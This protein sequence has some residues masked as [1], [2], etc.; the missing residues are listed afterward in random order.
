M[1]L[2][3][4]ISG[5]G[6][7]IQ[8]VAMSWLMATITPS[9]VMVALVQAATN[10]P[11][12]ILSIFAGAIVDNFNRR[13][14]MLIARALMALT[15]AT[16]T[17]LVAV[18]LI[19]PW[20]ILVFSFL[21]GCCIAFN[22]PAWQASVG[23]IVDRKD[24]AAAVTLT[25][26]GFNTVRSVGPALGGIILATFGPLTA[27]CLYTLGHFAP[28]I[29]VWRSK[30]KVP[31]PRL[32]PEAMLTAISDGIRF[33]SLSSEIK[34]ALGRGFLFGLAGIAIL[35]LLPLVVRDQLK[36][37]AVAYGILMAGFGAGALLAGL[38]STTLRRKLSDE[39]LLKLACVACATCTI[40]LSLTQTAA[41]AAIALMLGGAGWV[42]GWSGLSISVQWASP[43]WVVGRTISLYYAL[44]SCGLA[45]GS[46]LWG[47]VTES[48]SLSFALQ[49]STAASLGVA[50]LGLILPIHQR[51]DADVST[52]DHFEA[53]A[54]SLDLKPRSGPIAVKIEYRIAADQVEP[55]LALMLQRRRAQGRNGARRW[56]LTRNLHDTAVWTE[57]FRTPT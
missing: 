38:T 28:L 29:V 20:I 1:W 32:P 47:M 23:D 33:T 17:V 19:N 46:W 21:A 18:G 54:I 39:Q 15:A 5:L 12:F 56:I 50:L 44:T 51:K 10:L 49:A 42:L 2:A 26:V 31:V 11:A 9:S 41:V 30:W 55:F 4:L 16:L 8:T 3:G 6:W 43:R 57:T 13:R 25:S 34:T 22:D 45:V 24:L 52:P 40:S 35:A 27:F 48:Y 14:V 7:L 36:Q 37:G 53:P